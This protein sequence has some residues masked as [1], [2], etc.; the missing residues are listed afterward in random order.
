MTIPRF[1][2]SV[3]P[4]TQIENEHGDWCLFA[5][6]NQHIMDLY[7]RIAEL[8]EGEAILIALYNAGVDNWEGYEF[9]MDCIEDE[10]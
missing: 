8:E 4:G 2:M 5:H 3:V 6:V 7:S 1:D 10:Q 9:A